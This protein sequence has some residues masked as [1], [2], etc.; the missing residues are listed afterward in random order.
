MVTRFATHVVWFGEAVPAYEEAI[1]LVQSADIF[2]VIGST[3]SVYPVA[4]VH[5]IPHYKSVLY[6]SPSRSFS[7]STSI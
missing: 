3:L 6:R 5:E 2:I 4:L 1:R 7:C